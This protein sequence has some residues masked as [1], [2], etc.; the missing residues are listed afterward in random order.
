MTVLKR[1]RELKDFTTS[2]AKCVLELVDLLNEGTQ[3]EL[4]EWVL[5]NK[6][7]LLATLEGRPCRIVT[8]VGSTAQEVSDLWMSIK[9]ADD[10]VAEQLL[11]E[12]LFKA[13][14]EGRN[15]LSLTPED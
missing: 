6:E 8:D 10:T 2:R 4:G 5:R 13:R 12:A 9:D 14:K 3:N 7:T 1:G 11:R 15:D